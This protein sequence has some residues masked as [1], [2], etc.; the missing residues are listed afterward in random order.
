MRLDTVASRSKGYHQYHWNDSWDWDQV[1]APLLIDV[2]RDDRTIPTIPTLVHP[3]RN[4]PG[5]AISSFW[6]LFCQA[7][8]TAFV[9]ADRRSLCCSHC[10][11]RCT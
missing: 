3:A 9:S 8:Y 6:S 2:P 11:A 5:H 4:G 1:S 10:S 7:S